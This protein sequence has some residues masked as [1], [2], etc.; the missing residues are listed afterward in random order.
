MEK[1]Q[2]PR[3]VLLREIECD[4]Y[5]LQEAVN[6][7]GDKFDKKLAKYCRLTVKHMHLTMRQNM[8]YGRSK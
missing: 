1:I 4:K 2:L 3:E 6:M 8:I 5:N 7:M